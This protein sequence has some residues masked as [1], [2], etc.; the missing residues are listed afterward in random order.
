[1]AGSQGKGG[2]KGG[3]DRGDVRAEKRAQF[4]GERRRS[5]VPYVIAAVALAAVAVVGFVLVSG[6]GPAVPVTDTARAAT[7]DGGRATFRVDELVDGAARFFSA[8]VGGTSVKYFVVEDAKGDV[9][10]AFDACDVCYPAKKGYTQEGDV[11]VCNNC[12]RRFAIA[13]IG[14]VTG[15][16]NPAPVEAKVKDGQVVITASALAEGARYFQ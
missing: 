12:G 15:G 2:T 11:V 14:T 1:M 9:R 10:A 6:G 4:T 3:A 16:C 7:L 8:D 13:S 5:V